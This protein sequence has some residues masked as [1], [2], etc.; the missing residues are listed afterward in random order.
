[1]E[2]AISKGLVPPEANLSD[3]EI[4][5]LLFLPGFTTADQISAL[6]GRGVGMDVV[7]S[8]IQALGGRIAITSE[9]GKGTRFSISLPLTLAVL[10]GMVINV[11]GESLV[12]PLSAIIDTATLTSDDI[13]SLGP[14]TNVI[15]VRG[16]FV[17][18]YDLGA[19]LGYRAPK[20]SYE[21][22]IVLLTAQDDGERSA[23][24]VDAIMEQRQVVI[25][26]LQPSYGHIPGVA[27]A[28][29]LGDGQI[30][31]ILDP[32]DLVQNASGRTRG[33]DIALAG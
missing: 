31:L 19:E 4:D 18:L 12:V 24:V 11:A 9:P 23:L 5:N 20:S 10:D 3:G 13:R 33:F 6:S 29:I 32:A 14:Q 30:A 21:G 16:D 8:S 15:H 7:R 28:T 26:G 25:K 2:K 27:A 22:G 17:P 1:L